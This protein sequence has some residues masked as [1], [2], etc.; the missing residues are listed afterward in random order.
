MIGIFKRFA[1][2][3]V[4]HFTG[5]QEYMQC[6][7]AVEPEWLAEL[8]PVFFSIK[9]S[10]SSRLEARAKQKAAKAAMEDEMV[11]RCGRRRSKG[12]GGGG[13]GGRSKNRAALG[14]RHSGAAHA[15][16]A[17]H[18]RPVNC[19]AVFTGPC[20]AGC[21]PLAQSCWCR[22]RPSVGEVVHV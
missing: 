13:Q 21:F 8:G 3:G 19:F 20:S 6:V 5:A 11:N 22:P 1:D 9:E 14:D 7:T 4:V 10:H 12:A 2:A 16:A 18:L 17:P 15:H